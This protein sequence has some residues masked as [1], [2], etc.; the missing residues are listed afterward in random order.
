MYK[1]VI[2]FFLVV[3]GYLEF[4]YDLGSGPVT[5][6]NDQV[7]VDDGRRHSVFLKRQEVEGSIEVDHDYTEFGIAEGL[8]RT[9]NCRGNI[10]LGKLFATLQSEK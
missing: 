9:M 6:R 2:I 3:D 10:Y 4:S 1:F 7:K 8:T 5:I